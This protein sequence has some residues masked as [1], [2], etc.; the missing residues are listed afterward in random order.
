MAPKKSKIPVQRVRYTTLNS[1]KDK[2]KSLHKKGS[3]AFQLMH[4]GLSIS[5]CSWRLMCRQW[6]TTSGFEFEDDPL[7]TRID[8]IGAHWDLIEW[9]C[10]ISHLVMPKRIGGKRIRMG[11]KDKG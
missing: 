5:A 4:A 11:K 2:F 7:Q 6:K 8:I 10:F 1:P 3:V 9:V